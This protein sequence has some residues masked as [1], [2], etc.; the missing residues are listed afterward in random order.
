MNDSIDDRKTSK[1]YTGK[2]DISRLGTFIEWDGHSS[3]SWWP[4]ADAQTL[5]GTEGLFF[6]PILKEGESLC[7]FVDDV[8]RSFQIDHTSSSTVMGISAFR[9]E[10]A[11]HEFKGG[12][13]YPYNG[14]QFGSWC[15]DGLIYMGVTQTPGS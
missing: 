2:G 10:V 14:H 7:V 9:Y 1:V 5:K 15:P 13:T 3:L 12:L 6:H 4:G 11:S 8:M